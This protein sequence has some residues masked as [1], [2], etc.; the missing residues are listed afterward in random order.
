MDVG[1]VI[2]G[3]YRVLRELGRGGHARVFEVEHLQLQRRHALKVLRTSMG[4]DVH[5]RFSRE[6]RSAA[7]LDHPSVVKVSDF[8]STKA[9]APYLVM[10]MV[11]GTSLAER[12]RQLGPVEPVEALDLIARVARGVHHAHENGMVH[13]DLKP[14]NVMLRKGGGVKIVDF[15][16]AAWSERLDP[17]RLTQV[18][19]LF[20]TPAYMSPEQATAE[21][22][23]R[24]TDVYALG[25]MLWEMLMGRAPFEGA[26]PFETLQLQVE[27]PLPRLRDDLLDRFPELDAVVQRAAAKRPED[28]FEDADA[29]RRAVEDVLRPQNPAT[30]S[31][32]SVKPAT[33]ARLVLAVGLLLVLGFVLWWGASGATE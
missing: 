15:G 4:Q 19:E 10:E 26:T 21:S 23:D 20:G 6:A 32:P 14:H 33:H 29:F 30:E 11:E 18:G 31:L 17:N 8:G 27:Q 24:R 7:L 13:R 12:L 9:G 2:D 5:D 28:R 1:S 22:T 25:L 3:K 16:L